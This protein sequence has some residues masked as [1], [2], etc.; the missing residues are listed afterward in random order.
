MGGTLHAYSALP[1]RPGWGSS[2]AITGRL[3]DRD[4]GLP[5]TAIPAAAG[6]VW[7]C[8]L[9][10]PFVVGAPPWPVQLAAMRKGSHHL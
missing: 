10:P 9:R 2:L 7:R 6:S 5:L 4:G 1:D 8:R 3:M